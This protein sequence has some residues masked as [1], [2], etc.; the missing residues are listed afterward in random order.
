[1]EV[2]SHDPYILYDEDK[3]AAYKQIIAYNDNMEEIKAFI[4]I[5]GITTHT[6]RKKERYKVY[7]I[8]YT[9]YNGS[10]KRINKIIERL[11]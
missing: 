7:Q 11:H 2:I 10:K 4:P 8:N 6:V 9:L 3:H 1:M 5:G